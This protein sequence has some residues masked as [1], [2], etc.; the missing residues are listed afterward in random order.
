MCFLLYLYLA[1]S[2]K[3][4][5]LSSIYNIFL[6]F[7]DIQMVFKLYCLMQ[8]ANTFYN[9]ILLLIRSAFKTNIIL[10]LHKY[11]KKTCWKIMKF[12][13]LKNIYLKIYHDIILIK[14]LIFKRQ[15]K[16]FYFLNLVPDL[17]NIRWRILIETQVY[18]SFNAQKN[19]SFKWKVSIS[20]F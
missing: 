10:V 17:F 2:R 11:V 18:T 19:N 4:L 9:L 15:I 12:K 8:I 14:I 7:S 5:K 6:N 20:S 16:N 3:E 1:I 13:Y